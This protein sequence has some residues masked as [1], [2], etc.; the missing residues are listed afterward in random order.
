[1]ADRAHNHI[2]VLAGAPQC[3]C[4]SYTHWLGGRLPSSCRRRQRQRP[5]HTDVPAV[6]TD[7]AVM[8]GRFDR[9][10]SA[11][12]ADSLQ[13][14]SR[15]LTGFALHVSFLPRQSSHEPKNEANVRSY[16]TVYGGVTSAPLRRT[17]HRAR[18]PEPSERRPPWRSRR[19]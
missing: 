12:Q 5:A 4:S 18:R 3:F 14:G 10:G 6:T 2:Q 16:A 13:R 8:Y 11:G 17:L 9:D 15:R 7:E 1:M 19:P